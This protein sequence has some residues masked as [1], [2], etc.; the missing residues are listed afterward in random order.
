M[1][2]EPS[3]LNIYDVFLSGY[4]ELKVMKM[5]E[6]FYSFIINKTPAN[7]LL[8]QCISVLGTTQ[9][10]DNLIKLLE[11]DSRPIPVS[12]SSRKKFVNKTF[13]SWTQYE[14]QRLLAG[15]HK[16]GISDFRLVANFVGNGRTRSQCSQR[17]NR[18]LNPTIVKSPWTQ[19]EDI[20]LMRAV[21]INRDHSWTKVANEI[22]GRTD[23]QCRYRYQ[24]I[25]QKY[26]SDLGIKPNEFIT[27][28]YGI[29]IPLPMA[30]SSENLQEF[31][32]KKNVEMDSYTPLSKNLIDM[33]KVSTS[34]PY[35]L[36]NICEN[37]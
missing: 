20:M 29:Q 27:Q 35:S 37:N 16:F 33:L 30:Q 3:L 34:D 14:D 21:A 26:P 5:K 8:K 4:D 19:E 28:S 11:V 22:H 6:I 32:N 17:W 24:L 12:S 7:E 2:E 15:I 25:Y 10:L 18:S 1:A 36:F 23:V 31:S 13:N 9:P